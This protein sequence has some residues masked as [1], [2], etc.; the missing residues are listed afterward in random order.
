MS[1][2]NIKPA[3]LAVSLFVSTARNLDFYVRKMEC[4]HSE[5]TSFLTSDFQYIP[6]FQSAFC[7]LSILSNLLLGYTLSDAPFP[8]LPKWFDHSSLII[9]HFDH[10]FMETSRD[11]DVPFRILLLF[12]NLGFLLLAS[13]HLVV[14]I[15]EW[16]DH[17]YSSQP[18]QKLVVHGSR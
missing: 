11:N 6:L 14:V 17:D 13:T 16:N 1:T 12:S 15:A 2:L 8:R 7:L 3:E 4:V 5:R 9:V 10:L 18:G